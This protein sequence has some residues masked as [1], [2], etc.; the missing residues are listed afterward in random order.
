M[1]KEG[2]EIYSCALFLLRIDQKQDE[3]RTK[4]VKNLTAGTAR[5]RG[6]RCAN[7]KELKLA[8]SFRDRLGECDPLGA[9]RKAIGGI[10][11]IAP[12]IDAARAG[13]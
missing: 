3:V 5:R 8:L 10:L 2:G 1:R 6:P 11:D 4:L 12:G 9:D 13:L 7:G